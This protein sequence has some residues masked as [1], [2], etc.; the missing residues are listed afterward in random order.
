MAR[1]LGA[2]DR[3][4]SRLIEGLH[5][6]NDLGRMD[7]LAGFALKMVRVNEVSRETLENVRRLQLDKFRQLTRLAKRI[8]SDSEFRNFEPKRSQVRD[9]TI[10]LRYANVDIPAGNRREVKNTVIGALKAQF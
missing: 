3:D 7:R 6:A 9:A 5:L 2:I 4:G 8:L 1:D 10:T